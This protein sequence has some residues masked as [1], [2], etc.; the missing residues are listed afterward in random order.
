[1]NEE[2]QHVYQERE[3]RHRSGAEIRNK[4]GF[5]KKTHPQKLSEAEAT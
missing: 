2:T 5:K 1:M 4:P 3:E